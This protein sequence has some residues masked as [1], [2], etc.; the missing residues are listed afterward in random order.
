M[1]RSWMNYVGAPLLILM[2]V[3]P[4]YRDPDLSTA[5]TTPLI[6]AGLLWRGPAFDDPPRERR[7]R[8]RYRDGSFRAAPA[9]C[10]GYRRHR[11][12]RRAAARP[13]AGGD[14][15]R[16]RGAGIKRGVSLRTRRLPLQQG[17]S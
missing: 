11:G 3:F 6:V 4:R 5:K 9:P 2:G 10:A 17:P 14:L 12:S 1:V 8:R 16:P 7:Y 13:L 15:L